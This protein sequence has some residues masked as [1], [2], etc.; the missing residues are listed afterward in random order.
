MEAWSPHVYRQRGLAIGASNATV[1][2]ALAAYE[3][4]FEACPEATPVLTLAHLALLSNTRYEFL[5]SVVARERSPYFLFQISKRSSSREKRQIAVPNRELLRAQRWIHK[6]ILVHCPRTPTSFAYQPASS[7]VKCAALHSGAKWLVKLDICDFFNSILEHRVY[8]VFRGLGYGAL[9][10]LEM[11]R[12]CTISR[13]E[14]GGRRSSRQHASD[15]IGR[16]ASGNIGALPMGAPSSPILSNQVMIGFDKTMARKCADRDATYSR[17]ADDI[18]ISSSVSTFNKR[19]AI[20]L[21]K[22]CGDELKQYGLLLNQRKVRILPPGARKIVLGLI[23]NDQRPRISREFKLRIRQHYYYIGKVGAAAHAAARHFTS[24]QA[25]ERHLRG[26]LAFA[27]E[28]E[29][30]YAARVLLEH[31]RI[32]WLRLF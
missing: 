2:Q 13:H 22:F 7:I 26:L 16:Y 29:P 19:E 31:N 30:Q 15:Q 6:N 17:Y 9:I 14:I 8:G 11:A 18:F 5:R 24:I 3:C 25:L 1:E 20:A 32:D 21:I 23:V 27:K 12:I 10:S 4:V 28:V